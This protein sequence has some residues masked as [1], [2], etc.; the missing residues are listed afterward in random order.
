MYF[1][2]GTGDRYVPSRGVYVAVH[3]NSMKPMTRYEGVR[4][5]V[6]MNSGSH[7]LH[8]IQPLVY[9]Y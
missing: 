2:A 5:P 4:V 6:G 7:S 1:S 8:S 9:F 3:N